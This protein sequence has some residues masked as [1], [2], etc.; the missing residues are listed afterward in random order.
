MRVQNC[1]QLFDRGAE[2]FRLA[3]HVLRYGVLTARGMAAG[4]RVCTGPCA[5][6]SE[7]KTGKNNEGHKSEHII[8]SKQARVPRA[9]Y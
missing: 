6:T 3:Y 1:G 9:K 5:K 2:L 7:K 8:S 4:K